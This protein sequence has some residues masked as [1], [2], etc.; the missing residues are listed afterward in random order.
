MSPLSYTEF[1]LEQRS[2]FGLFS[3]P[4]S[5][6]MFSEIISTLFNSVDLE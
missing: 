3:L 2:V 6:I 5:S 4:D 1:S